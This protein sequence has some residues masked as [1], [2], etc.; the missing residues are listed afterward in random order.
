MKFPVSATSSPT[1]NTS[2]NRA[3]TPPRTSQRRKPTFHT[4]IRP[5]VQARSVQEKPEYPQ[6]FNVTAVPPL[7]ASVDPA[8]GLV[9]LRY[10][11]QED[12]RLL[13]LLQGLSDVVSALHRRMDTLE[14]IVQD[15]D[16]CESDGDNEGDNE[17]DEDSDNEGDECYDNEGDEDDDGEGDSDNEG[18]GE[19]DSE[20][21][22]ESDNE[23][24]NADEGEEDTCDE[25]VPSAKDFARDTKDPVVYLESKPNLV[26]DCSKT[27]DTGSKLS[28]S[29]NKPGNS[30]ES[31][32]KYDVVIIAN[33]ACI[34]AETETPCLRVEM[35]NII[36]SDVYCVQ[37]PTPL[38][39]YPIGETSHV[40]TLPAATIIT[41]NNVV[42][43][44]E[45]TT[46][47]ATELH[48]TPEKDI[49]GGDVE[50]VSKKITETI[51]PNSEISDQ[52][53][54]VR[55][56]ADLQV[57]E[58]TAK[59]IQYRVSPIM[60]EP[61]TAIHP[62][63][64]PKASMECQIDSGTTASVQQS[65]ESPLLTSESDGKPSEIGDKLKPPNKR[66]RAR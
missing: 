1:T 20:N 53:L 13:Q 6:P 39:V 7:Y 57:K 50:E 66:R 3:L 55:L 47:N 65:L 31:D 34:G 15:S 32:G 37:K 60:T 62:E 45:T 56:L 58:N 49:S 8:S 25:D 46:T 30:G 43:S 2:R 61:E 48:F 44:I 24:D 28:T 18:E 38:E 26:R 19:G 41:R 42:E 29:E 33:D 4:E 35:D 14:S 21:E 52:A 11:Q 22:G 63:I 5:A 16:D 9:T 54:L 27:S 12:S 23:G 17:G 64:S 36:S 40:G 10:E 59:H 51:T